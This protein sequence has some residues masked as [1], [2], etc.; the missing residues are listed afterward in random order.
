MTDA[1]VIL[2]GMRAGDHA[3]VTR[4]FSSDDLRQFQQLAAHD[5]ATLQAVPEPLIGALFSYLLGVELPGFGQI[6][7]V[8]NVARFDFGN[9]IEGRRQVLVRNG[10][11]TNRQK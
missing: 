2:K 8:G 6:D 11:K 7:G 10:K 9:R 4:S 3:S 1:P 5:G